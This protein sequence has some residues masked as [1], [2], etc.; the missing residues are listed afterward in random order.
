LNVFCLKTVELVIFLK[1]VMN[2]TT[3]RIVKNWNDPDVMR[4]TPGNSGVWDNI[5]FTLDPVED[6][7]YLIMFNNRMRID[8]NARCPRENVW[9]L[10]QEPYIPEHPEWKTEKHRPF[11][12]VFTH[13]LPAY[14]KRY[15]SSQP[16]VPWHVNKSFD[17]LSSMPIPVKQK[18]ISSITSNLSMLPGQKKRRKFIDF[19][20]R[21][22]ISGLDFFGKGSC[23]I[24]DKWDGLA[25]Y[26]FSI[27]IENS[28]TPDYWTEKLAD[29][30][31][32]WTIPFYYGCPNLEKYF[33]KDS[34]I[35]IDIE[36]Q[37]KSLE[38]IT[39]VLKKEDW[40]KRFSALQKAREL[41]L[42]KYQVFPYITELIHN[43]KTEVSAKEKMII[44]ANK[45]IKNPIRSFIR[46][47]KK[48][49]Q[50]YINSRP[51]G[52]QR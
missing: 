22:N 46:Y 36:N 21:E 34:F 45:I 11:Y 44:P 49:T 33:P 25:P 29:C 7:D 18:S 52:L 8:T 28:N 20:R 47:L 39:A 26:K 12:K 40:D 31:L 38:I 23:Y 2:R 14:S 3:V 15:I 50:S 24:E 19:I 4:Q 9:L 13:H 48:R 32:A 5:K 27:A 37:E 51:G 42:N 1:T 43:S 6:C 17:E 30:F 10:M 41:I 35:R 16:A